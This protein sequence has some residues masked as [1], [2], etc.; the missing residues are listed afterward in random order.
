MESS[1]R[2]Q[3][4]AQADAARLRD[5]IMGSTANCSTVGVCTRA[6]DRDEVA[7]QSARRATAGR[8]TK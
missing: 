3:V 6:G 1:P 8:L 5:M 7:S 2:L 4:Q